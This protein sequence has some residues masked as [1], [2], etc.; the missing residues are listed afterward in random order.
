MNDIP[1]LRACN[2]EDLDALLCHAEAIV[3]S[4]EAAVQSTR[5]LNVNISS[6]LLEASDYARQEV[7]DSH[8][9]LR[10]LELLVLSDCSS[11]ST[12][13]VGHST[14]HAYNSAI[15][16]PRIFFNTEQVEMLRSAGYSWSNIAE[17]VQ[18]SRTTLWRRLQ[19]TDMARFTDISDHE[20]DDVVSSIQGNNPNIGRSLTLGYL[21]H[22]MGIRVQQSRVRES[23]VRVNPISTSFRWQQVLWRRRYC[24]PGPNSLWH[25]D[26][27]HSLIR[28]R[29]VIH[30]GIDGFSRY[31]TFLHCSTNNRSDTVFS[32][33]RCTVQS[34]G[35]PSRVRTDHGGEN[36]LVCA[37]MITTRGV[38][39]GGHI[40][41]S[42]HHNQRI[43]RLWR[44]VY[45]CVASTF[46]SVFYFMEAHGIL[47]PEDSLDL[48]VLHCVYLTKINTH[49]AM[50]TDAWNSHPLRMEH[51]W[52]PRRIWLN[53]V[54]DPQRAS[55]TA[56]RDIVE[57]IPE[58]GLQTFR[59]DF[60]GPLPT[61]HSDD[62][63]V[64]V[65]DTPVPL[66][67]DQL[68]VFIDTVSAMNSAN[69]GI[70][71]F[72]QAKALLLSMLH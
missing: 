57:G 70:D 24:V 16:R 23:L 15:G 40:A 8:A 45:R 61:I 72:V 25:I 20:L 22:N 13:V 27:N 47:N 52:S 56:I 19:Y 66:P 14:A 58:E 34:C 42:S 30:S 64:E 63:T 12:P 37:Y 49:L 69:Y 71:V 48:F 59:I 51:N 39:R 28:W 1:T 26:G 5:Y 67:M 33:F 9:L 3:N 36:I 41:G 68:Q 7:L 60:F 29:F 65:P 62:D 46:H 10:D 50:F 43:E 44:D 21:A 35:I 55:Q 2:A 6:H 38:G 31:I 4:I 53:G 11:V 32:L 54:L 17:C 18:I